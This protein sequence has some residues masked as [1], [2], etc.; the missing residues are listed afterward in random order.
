MTTFNPKSVTYSKDAPLNSATIEAKRAKVVANIDRWLQHLNGEQSAPTEGKKKQSPIWLSRLDGD[1]HH[2][3]LKYAQRNIAIGP[4]GE[5]RLT[6]DASVDEKEVFDYLKQQ[7]ADG[8]YDK[9][10][11]AISD[12]V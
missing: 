3:R 2:Y 5:D 9:S 8:G 7:V 4:K 10:I 6:V 12:A 11:K 1:R